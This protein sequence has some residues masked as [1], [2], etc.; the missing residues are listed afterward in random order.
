MSDSVLTFYEPNDRENT[1]ENDIVINT[2]P[3]LASLY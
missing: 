3:L 1:Q 2:V